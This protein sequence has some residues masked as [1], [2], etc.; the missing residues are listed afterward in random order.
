MEIDTKNI[1]VKELA[2]IYD[3]NSNDT[4]ISLYINNFDERFIKKRSNACSSILKKDTHLYNNFEKTMEM[5]SDYIN[6]NRRKGTIIF[7]SYT[8]NFFRVYKPSLPIENLFVVDSSP[9]IRPIVELMDRY[10]RYGLILINSHKAKIYII[11]AG[12]VE[13]EKNISKTI[14]SKHKKGGWSQARFQRIRKG[15]INQFIKEAVDDVEKFFSEEKINHIV[16]AGPGE[17]KM[18][19]KE[20]LPRYIQDKI[21][22]IIDENF[23]EMESKIIFDTEDIV[24]KNEEKEKEEMIET[25]ETEV[26][27]NGLAV[28]GVEETMEAVR[29]GKVNLL[30]ITRGMKIAGWKCER[31]KVMGIGMKKQCPYCEHRTTNIDLIEEIIELAESSDARTEFF[32]NK[33]LEDI[34]GIAALLRYK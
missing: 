23:Y 28:Y 15:A 32:D 8:N 25:L 22:D 10:E 34:G 13:Y 27:R 31:C 20:K 19:F 4:F 12:N 33:L 17:A 18:W 9:Y 6:K 30:F 14:M 1:D 11:Y 5:I 24:E 2:E 21:I 7:A 29:N 3:P 16:I 26:L